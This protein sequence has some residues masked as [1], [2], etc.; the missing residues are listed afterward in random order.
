MT[1]NRKKKAGIL[2]VLIS[3]SLLTTGCAGNDSADESENKGNNEETTAG[4][5]QV[6]S[7]GESVSETEEHAA[8]STVTLTEV[9]TV[10]KNWM[11][12]GMKMR[13]SKC[14]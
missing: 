12:P 2:A 9:N 8:E 6:N 5:Q 1:K 10:K 11:I 7:E 3:I 13:L 4:E 14:S